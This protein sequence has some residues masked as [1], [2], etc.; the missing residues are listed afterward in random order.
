MYNHI[1]TRLAYWPIFVIMFAS[2]IC[3]GSIIGLTIG[4]MD[5]AS[6]GIFGGA[7][8]ALLA[9]LASGFIGLLYTWVFNI[10]APALGGIS[11]KTAPAPVSSK[12]NMTIQPTDSSVL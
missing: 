10:L 6:V 2:G 7:F 3:I 8:I 4:L 9:G 12:D 11:M 5:R 1:V